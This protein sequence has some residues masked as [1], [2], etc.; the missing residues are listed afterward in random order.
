MLLAIGLPHG[1]HTFPGF[2]SHQTAV[3]RVR[4]I[5]QAD[6]FVSGVVDEPYLLILTHYE[7]AVV[8][9]RQGASTV[10]IHPAANCKMIGAKTDR[11][12]IRQMPERVAAPRRV[13]LQP[14]QTGRRHGQFPTLDMHC[15]GLVSTHH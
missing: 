5:G 9:R 3:G 11:A 8:G 12:M 15:A 14:E 4:V 13:G 2:V 6:A 1:E 10:A 7:H